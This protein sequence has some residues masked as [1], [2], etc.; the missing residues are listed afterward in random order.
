MTLDTLES[1]LQNTDQ[2]N[3]KTYVNSYTWQNVLLNFHAL[4]ITLEVL[5]IIYTNTVEKCYLQSCPI[6]KT[7]I[8][9]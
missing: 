3:K 8:V 6:L 1:F 9:S 7:L 5:R 4:A 2:T